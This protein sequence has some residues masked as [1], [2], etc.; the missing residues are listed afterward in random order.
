MTVLGDATIPSA[1]GQLLVLA[2]VVPIG[3]L[4]APQTVRKDKRTL[5]AMAVAIALVIGVPVYAV[6]C[7]VC[8]ICKVCPWYL[9]PLEC[10]FL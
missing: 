2:T 4:L 10:W 9:C 7:N 5:V 6:V 8:E 1:L 3:L